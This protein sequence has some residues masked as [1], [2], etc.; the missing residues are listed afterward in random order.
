M[1]DLFCSSPTVKTPHPNPCLNNNHTLLYMSNRGPVCETPQE[2][3]TVGAHAVSIHSWV[4][5][6]L[7][8]PKNFTQFV[9]LILY[10]NAFCLYHKLSP[11]HRRGNQSLE[12]DMTGPGSHNLWMSKSGLLSRYV[13]PWSV[14]L[15]TPKSIL[16]L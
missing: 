4:A 14:S 6:S 11:L 15:T 13:R 1:S 5:K 12:M 10:G 7:L 3:H 9:L 8:C 2:E 16:Q